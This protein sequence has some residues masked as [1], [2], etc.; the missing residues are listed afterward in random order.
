MG[1]R[2]IKLRKS[3]WRERIDYDALD[4][5][6]V[7][8]P[9]V[10]CSFKFPACHTVICTYL[11]CI[12]SILWFCG[13]TTVRRNQSFRRRVFCTSEPEICRRHGEYVLYFSI[14]TRLLV[15]I[16]LMQ[17]Y[18]KMFND[19]NFEERMI[20]EFIKSDTLLS[21]DFEFA[22]GRGP[23]WMWCEST[24]EYPIY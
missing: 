21:F 6:K 15:W 7:S 4:R 22:S 2:P 14:P 9:L 24:M 17:G 10:S 20:K 8:F 16:K 3:N 19:D 13:R 1:N 12:C 5:Q 11:L 23:V 18:V